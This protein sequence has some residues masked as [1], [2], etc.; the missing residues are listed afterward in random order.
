M[1]KRLAAKY[2]SKRT[3]GGESTKETALLIIGPTRQV[4]SP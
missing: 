3:G 4:S 1:P 2:K